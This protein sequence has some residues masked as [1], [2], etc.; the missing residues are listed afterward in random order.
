MIKDKTRIIGKD[1]AVA[2]MLKGGTLVRHMRNGVFTRNDIYD[3]NGEYI[4]VL[5]KPTYASIAGLITMDDNKTLPGG[6]ACYRFTMR[7][8]V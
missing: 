8:G 7:G 3:G 5:R 6:F 4:G 2:L 1:E